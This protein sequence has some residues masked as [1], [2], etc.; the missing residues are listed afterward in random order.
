[1]KKRILLVDDEESILSLV[2]ATLGD[3][4]EYD[5]FL[6]S[7]GRKAIEMAQQ[8]TPE[9]VVLDMLMPELDGCDV[10]AAIKRDPAT[11]G[12]KIIILTALTQPADRDRAL[13]AGADD[14]LSKPFS[15]TILLEKINRLVD[16]ATTTRA[17]PAETPLA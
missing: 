14:F 2:S 17:A 9:V 11:A 3:G 6:A 12:A 4:D 7:D 10:C 16:S 1:M 5:L 15:P 8:Y 13:A